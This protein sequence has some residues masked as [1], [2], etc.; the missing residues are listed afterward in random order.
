MWEAILGPLFAIINKV[1]PDPQ[2]QAAAKLALVQAQQ[3]GELEEIKA[4]LSAIN[5]EGASQDKW[6]SRAR[7]TFLYVIYLFLVIAIPYAILWCFEPAY[8]D[9]MATGL[10]KWLTAIPESLYQLFGLGYL[11][12]TGGRSFEKWVGKSK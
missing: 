2:Q 6:T 12:Y 7:P 1:I 8:A 5:T 9:R 10:N 4:S 11:G 3:N